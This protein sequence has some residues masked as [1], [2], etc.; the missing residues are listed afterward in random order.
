MFE[1]MIIFHCSPTLAGMKTGNLFACPYSAKNEI[2]ENIRRLNKKLA[3]KGLRILPVFTFD[4]R[5][6]IYVYRPSRLKEDFSKLP[7]KV[8]LEEYGYPK[9]NPN[10]CITKL[11]KKLHSEGE[12]P[13][14]IG[15]FLGYPAEDVRGFIENKARCCKCSGC[16]KVYGDPQKA[17]KL[18]KKYRKCTNV[19][20]AQWKNGK[21]IERLTVAENYSERKVI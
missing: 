6:L 21:S 16:W 11:I 7:V 2:T 10:Q 13:H 3:P 17:E 1:E 15:L 19:Y 4:K 9:N 18:F 14:E 20:F 8:I 5:A 12:F